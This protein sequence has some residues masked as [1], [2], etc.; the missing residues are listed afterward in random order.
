MAGEFLGEGREGLLWERGKLVTGGVL[1]RSMGGGGWGDSL[2]GRGGGRH[3]RAEYSVLEIRS[4]ANAERRARR[5][6]LRG[7]RCA[8]GGAAGN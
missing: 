3:G 7:W 8:G 6:Q 5:K 1:F 2:C 4:G